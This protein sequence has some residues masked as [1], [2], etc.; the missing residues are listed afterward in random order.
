[1][2]KIK[3]IFL[4][5]LLAISCITD[6]TNPTQVV[7]NPSVYGTGEYELIHE[8]R[9]REYYYYEP[10][11]LEENAPLIVVLHGYEGNKEQLMQ[12]MDFRG[13]ADQNRFTLVYPQGL[14]D[15]GGK[16]HWNANLQI[17][18]INDIGFLTELTEQL[19]ETYDLN[20]DNVFVCGFSNGGFMAYE[21]AI[22]APETFNA[23]ASI[24]GT[25][26]LGTWEDRT[27]SVPKSILQI[28]GALD[29]VVPITGMTNLYGGWGGA[30]G[31]NQIMSF[32]AEQLN[33]TDYNKEDTDLISINQ[34][35]NANND[36][37]LWY[38]LFKDMGHELPREEQH[39][40]NGTDLVW[41]FFELNMK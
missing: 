33:Y 27:L 35:S 4:F 19:V 36:L 32:W 38:Y 18:T 10:L 9:V 31:M 17:S 5:V 6:E 37:Y 14:K 11:L 3:S 26:S 7:Q 23:F 39:G 20:Q 16:N 1:M 15:G 24:T 41:E 12:W 21:L 34:Y 29:R 2:K 40:I 28:S 8:G 13:L 22:K 30:P 25:M